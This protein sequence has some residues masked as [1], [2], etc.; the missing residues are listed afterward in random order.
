M[1]R[2]LPSLISSLF[3]FG[4]ILVTLA[5]SP[6]ESSAEKIRVLLVDGQN[7]HN[8]VETSPVLVAL[9]EQSGRFEVTVATS[10]AGP[11]R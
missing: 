6:A 7:N 11:P 3:L 5:W 10:P 9:M 4:I 8:W 2:V 1:Q